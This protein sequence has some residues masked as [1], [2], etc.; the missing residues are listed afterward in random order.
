M[1]NDE[2][3]IVLMTAGGVGYRVMVSSGSAQNWRVGQEVEIQTYLAVRETALDLYGFVDENERALFLKF[4][5]VSGVGPKTALHILSLGS[6]G[7]LSSAISRGDVTHL[8]K[9]SGIG[10]KTAER[11]VVELKGKLGSISTGNSKQVKTSDAVSDVIDGLVA[12]GYSALQARDIVK[13]LDTDGK[14]S[15]QLLR[16]ALTIK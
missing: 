13:E 12:M 14:S 9:V 6:V 10:K 11:L 4:L 2:G 16:E 5:D 3:E 1:G 15:E 8:T 7:D